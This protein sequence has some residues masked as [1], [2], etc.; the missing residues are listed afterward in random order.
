MKSMKQNRGHPLQAV[1][2][3][4]SMLKLRPLLMAAAWLAIALSGAVAA[5][6][7]AGGFCGFG[8]G[9]AEEPRSVINANAYQLNED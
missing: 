7:E 1:K 9:A 5:S 3:F 4:T 6:A 8:Y 2:S